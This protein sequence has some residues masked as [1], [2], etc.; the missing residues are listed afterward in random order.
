M[1]N[2]INTVLTAILTQ[3]M[4]LIITQ[5]FPISVSILYDRSR[6]F[7]AGEGGMGGTGFWR[8]KIHLI[9]AELMTDFY[10]WGNLETNNLYAIFEL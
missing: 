10:T 3:F 5:G 1:F 9:I 2:R 7:W 6:F 4:L 8:A